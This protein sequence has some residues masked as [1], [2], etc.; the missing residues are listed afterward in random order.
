MVSNRRSVLITPKYANRQLWPH[1]HAPT[2]RKTRFMIRRTWLS[3]IARLWRW[4]LLTPSKRWSRK[5]H[6]QSYSRLLQPGRSALFNTYWFSRIQTIY[7]INLDISTYADAPYDI[8]KCSRH[9][10]SNYWCL[11]VSQISAKT[12]SSTSSRL[13]FVFWFFFYLFEPLRRRQW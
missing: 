8:F 4:P 13:T 1:P 3:I 7:S 5:L 2:Y 6:K 9:P 11:L 10:P 12:P